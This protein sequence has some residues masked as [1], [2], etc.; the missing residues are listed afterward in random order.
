MKITGQILRY[1]FLFA[2]IVCG[3]CMSAQESYK[4]RTL[5]PKGGFYYDGVKDILFDT[6]GFVWILMDN[7]LLRFDGNEYKHY[8]SQFKELDN[9]V[10][11]LFHE[12]SADASGC[13]LINTNNGIYKFSAYSKLEDTGIKNAQNMVVDCWDNIWY[14][15]S[16]EIHRLDTRTNTIIKPRYDGKTVNNVFH[17]SCY[18]GGMYLGTRYNQIY[19]Y[20][21][22]SPDRLSLF[23]SFPEEYAIISVQKNNDILWVL[24]KDRGLF[25][26]DVKTGK[27]IGWIDTSFDSTDTPK[28]IKKMLVDKDN[29]LWIGTQEGLYVLNPNTGE[30]KLHI[31]SETNLLTLPNNSVWEIAEDK[32]RNLWIG[33]YAGGLSYVNLNEGNPFTTYTPKNSPLSNGLVSC[34]AEDNHF[35]WVGTEGGGI[36][37]IS[38]GNRSHFYYNHSHEHN[39]LSHNNVKSLAKDNHNRLWIA[40]FRGGLDYLDLKTNRFHHFLKSK[41]ENSLFNND[42]R[43]VVLEGDSGLWIAYQMDKIAISFLSFKDMSFTHYFYDDASSENFI[44]DICKGNKNDL[45]IL[46]RENLYHLDSPHSKIKQVDLPKSYYLGGQSLY[47]DKQ[48]NLWIGTLGNGF[49]RYDISNNELIKKDEILQYNIFAIH[50][51]CNIQDT[52]LWLGTNNGLFKYDIQEDSYLRFDENDGLQGQVYYPLSCLNGMD[53]RLYFGGSNGFSVIDLDKIKINPNKPQAFISDFFI[54]SEKVI[55]VFDNNEKAGNGNKKITLTHKQSNF[56]FKFSSDSYLIPE[57]NIFKYRLKN[58]NDRW[59][60]TDAS[61]RT[62]FYN[63][64]PAGTYAFEIMTANNDGVWSD[65]P[66]VIEIERLPSPWLSWYAFTVYLLL[67]VMIV[68]VVVYYYL[69]KKKLK[70]RLYLDKLEKEKKEEI[71]QSQLRFFTNISHDFRTPLSLILAS[72]DNLKQQGIDQSLYRILNN[73]ARRLLNLVNELMDFRTVE[74]KKLPLQ[75]QSLDINHLIDSWTFDFKE[76]AQTRN[77]TFNVSLDKELPIGLYADKSILEKIFMNLLNNAFKYT[78]DGGQITVESH[79]N[80]QSFTSSY[81]YY[82]TV[83]ESTEQQDDV[84]LIVFRDTGRGIS[85]ES[86][87]SVFER[88][89]KVNTNNADKHLGTGIGLALVKSLVLLHKGSITL[90]SEPGKGTDIVVCLPANADVYSDSEI[91]SAEAIDS[92]PPS[93]AHP[94]PKMESREITD[95]AEMKDVLLREKKRILLVEDNHDLRMLILNFL[96]PHYEIVEAENGEQASSILAETEVDLILSDIM[97]PVKDGISLCKE[98]K[99]N[100]N[101]SHIPFVLLTAKTE[102][103]SKLEGAGSGADLYFEKPIDFNLLLL[104]IQNIFK[105]QL[106]LREYYA[107]NYFSEDVELSSNEHDNRFLK[108][109][110]QIIDDSINQPNVDVNYLAGELSMS[111]SKLYSKLK[112]LTGKSIVEFILDYRLRKAARLIIEEDLSMG[113]VMERVGIK[114]QSYFTSVF[115]KEFGETPAVFAANNKKK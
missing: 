35:L 39:S 69:D 34:F 78:D 25:K 108:N 32:R 86:I 90:Y 115:K 111:R 18:E 80:R 40:M 67:F 55:P 27:E 14:T 15:Q 43:K 70:M 8:Y 4:F 3:N 9:R 49:L 76:H 114:S 50:S 61:G 73:N 113:Q 29:M 52:A 85:E 97:M 33:T 94:T 102:L 53:N 87:A 19:H 92:L 66:T 24:V 46:T 89:Y 30:Y 17:Y 2:I 60:V 28:L 54:D 45:W 16:K 11:W 48:N 112:A 63:K 100:I 93:D 47:M 68:A 51:I 105:R 101:T 103:E 26:L 22:H 5:S 21:Y 71:H 20:D 95:R 110:I 42:L 77:I 91:L 82:H 12:I 104:S 88:F 74:N 10:K 59:I 72:L 109:L 1:F 106:Q 37:R 23:Y 75:V 13:I 79:A 107:K 7:D 84:F 99:N 36:N 38:K 58:Y 44:F 31:H 41:E 56:G 57:K 62:A 83:S 65:S 81:K 96:S 6:H 98:V 64:V